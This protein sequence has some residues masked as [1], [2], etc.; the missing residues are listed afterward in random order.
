MSDDYQLYE[1][2]DEETGE[3]IVFGASG[4]RCGW[5][6]C[7]ARE[8]ESHPKESIRIRLDHDLR[9]AL[10]PQYFASEDCANLPYRDRVATRA[11]EN[12]LFRHIDEKFPERDNKIK[13]D[14]QREYE[15]ARAELDAAYKRF[16]EA[17][18]KVRVPN[19]R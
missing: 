14:N 4:T 15:V 10:G 6:F 2:T 7:N 12:L 17:E 11:A 5:R 18:N 19:E 13:S 8:P 9:W 1:V 16:A 3:S